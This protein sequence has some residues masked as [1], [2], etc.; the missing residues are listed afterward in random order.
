MKMPKCAL[1]RNNRAKR[2]CQIYQDKFIC[3]SCCA[4]L[5]NKECEE[6]RHYQAA[7]QYQS[8]KS[9]KP[10]RKD[11]IMEVNEKVENAVDKA[12]ELLERGK[13]EKARE[14]LNELEKKHP[15][16]H[17]VMYGLGTVH[18]IEGQYDDAIKYFTKATDIFPYFIEAYFNMGVAYKNKF[19]IG[20]AVRAMNKVI[21][22]GDS[23]HEQV[24]QAKELISEVENQLRKT[25]GMTLDQYFISQDKFDTA[26]SHMENGKW[27]EA[28]FGF[29]ECL[30]VHEDHPQSYGNL[31]ICYAQLGQK[32]KAIEAFDKALEIDP[33]YEPAIANKVMVERIQEG[34]KLH[35]AQFKSIEYYKD[36]PLKKKSYLESL[37]K[38]FR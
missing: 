32:A 31:G 19:D 1:C 4:E 23:E 14:I 38:K 22:I 15:R 33:K 21:E 3:P 34:E 11:F 16:N 7:K 29:K 12:L 2:K 8:S 25:T 18:A 36:Y 30:K 35:F 28:I 37:F 10:V 6:C 26:F 13:A 9:Q 5:R 24:Q 20:N 17:M 27:E